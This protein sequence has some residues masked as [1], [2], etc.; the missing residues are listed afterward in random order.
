MSELSEVTASETRGNVGAAAEI[1]RVGAEVTKAEPPVSVIVTAYGVAPYIA[2]TLDSVFAQ[3]LPVFEVIVVNDGSPDAAELERALAPYMP[4]LVYI[5]QENR[6]AG[7]ARN[8][9]LRAARAPLVAF[10]DGDDLWEPTYLEEQLRHM[11]ENDLDLSYTDALLFGDSEQAGRTYM[12][13]APS[14]GP[15]S[16]LSLVRGEC[17]V[18]TS[19]VVASRAAVFD[20]GLFDESLRNAQDFDLWARLAR[21]GAL[22]GYQRRVLAR[23]RCREGSLTGDAR[24]RLLRDLRITR[25]VADTYDLNGDERAEVERMLARHAAAIELERGKRL[26]AESKFAEAREALEG[27]RR[28]T[29]GWKLSVAL[30]MLK[31]APRLFVKLA[32]PRLRAGA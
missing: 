3:T 8:T 7:G 10:L 6:G 27:A 23:Y 2:E 1:V 24:H 28:I 18:I 11:R 9:G 19:G 22:L 21:R 16:F 31:V 20:V 14:D 17:N 12:E 5:A 29:P 15:V 13:I 26:L 25:H 4:R 32:G 30:L